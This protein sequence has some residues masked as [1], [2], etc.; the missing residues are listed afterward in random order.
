MHRYK[1]QLKQLIDLYE[2]GFILLP[3]FERRSEALT[4]V[5]NTS[6][7]MD[8]PHINTTQQAKT[9]MYDMPYN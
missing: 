2:N 7:L 5:M 4:S 1:A 3:D 8:L 6:I 9:T